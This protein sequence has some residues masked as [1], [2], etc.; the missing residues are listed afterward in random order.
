MK[1]K[2]AQSSV[3]VRRNIKADTGCVMLGKSLDFS[4]PQFPVL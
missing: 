4:V 2:K 1:E 3:G